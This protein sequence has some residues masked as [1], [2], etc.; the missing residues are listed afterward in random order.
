[1]ATEHGI[2]GPVQ[3]LVIGDH[4][5]VEIVL[6]PGGSVPFMAPPRPAHDLVG[7]VD[8]IEGLRLDVVAGRD[9][10]LFALRGIP[11]VGKTALA[12]AIAHDPQVGGVFVGGV[13]W[14][15][16]GP[17]PDVM[18]LLANWGA[19]LGISGEQLADAATP[20]ALAQI[21]HLAIGLR[22]MFLV[23]DDAWSVE[24]A[25]TFRLGGPNCVHLLTTRIPE[26]AA[27]FAAH[28]VDVKELGRD[29]GSQLLT[30]LAPEAAAADPDGVRDLVDLVAGLP[31]A[32]VLIGNFLRVRAAGGS[33]R[34]VRDTIAQL[35]EAQHRLSVNE[36]RG[37][38][39]STGYGTS[40]SLVASIGMSD[41]AL[42]P[43]G[44][45]ALRDI[46][47][48]PAK[49]N[50]FGEAAASDVLEHGLDDLDRLVDLGLVEHTGGER[51][52][53]HQAIH[54][55]ASA[56]GR[57]VRARERLVRHYVEALR[58][59]EA[60]KGMQML[61]SGPPGSG[62]PDDWSA[63]TVNVL[64]ALDS[65]HEL[66]MH[67][68]LVSGANDFAEHLNRRGLLAQAKVHLERALAA[69]ACGDVR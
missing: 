3:G 62:P 10:A 58:G 6:P 48:F 46:T 12:I 63:D 22:R 17:N 23:V 1:M 69:A 38:L 66:G 25:L 31:L 59:I 39:E 61:P 15:G 20:Q 9:S 53:L 68:E 8:L 13:L 49:P 36:P 65:A 40:L 14:A 56:D 2:Y 33:R 45:Q 54:D 34:R 11:G 57:G 55:Y 30:E 37:V 32:L 47:A 24:A 16:L 28:A 19:A 60:S 18:T 21:V 29:A 26:V 51:Y 27:R 41:E 52:T 67:A 43:G 50:T 42:P 44:R 5:Q 4:N 64:A 35:R 7:R